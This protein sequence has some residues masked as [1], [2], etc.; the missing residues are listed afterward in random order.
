[1][2]KTNLS[3]Q[4]ASSHWNANP[5][6][7]E[8][9]DQKPGENTYYDDIRNYRYGYETPFIVRL[10]ELNNLQN[11]EVLEIGVGNGIDAGEIV[12]GGGTYTGLDITK[13]HL[14]LSTA[15]LKKILKKDVINPHRLME[16]DL[17]STD[18]DR[19]FDVV[20]SVGVLHHIEHEAD[21]LKKIKTLLNHDGTL[22]I[23]LYSKYSFFGLYMYLT[24][25][26][27]NRCKV[28]LQTWQSHL[29]EKTDINTPV[30]IKVRS[31]RQVKQIL[32]ESGFKIVRY[33]KRGFVQNYIPVFGKFLKPDGIV[34]NLLGSV[35][36]WY[37][38]V[39]CR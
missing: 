10:F 7:H 4:K 39:W 13:K 16:G 33:H 9:S 19:K 18:L 2:E 12:K 25:I 28:S 35:L 34:L 20:Y 30:T 1:M 23:A 3:N 24:W 17:L 21:Y 6:G 26:I 38:V 31:F 14:D 36:G 15:Y 29:A 37:H 5:V 27:K 22:R 32:E 11:K 8:R